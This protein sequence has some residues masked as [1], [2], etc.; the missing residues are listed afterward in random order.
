MSESVQPLSMGGFLQLRKPLTCENDSYLQTS[1][2][3]HDLRLGGESSGAIVRITG[4]QLVQEFLHR[5]LPRLCLMKFHGLTPVVS[6]N[7]FG[8][9]RRSN[10][11]SFAL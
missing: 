9:I 1:I 4:L 10:S 6:V 3:S 11:P 7:F 5:A 2:F 8:G